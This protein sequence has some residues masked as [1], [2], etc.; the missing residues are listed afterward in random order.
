MGLEVPI[1]DIEDME[2]LYYCIING[3][4]Q[5]KKRYDKKWL[6]YIQS[7]LVHDKIICGI[8]QYTKPIY[9]GGPKIIYPFGPFPEL[10]VVNL[11]EGGEVWPPPHIPGGLIG[12]IISKQ[13]NNAVVELTQ[14]GKMYLGCYMIN[15]Y[16]GQS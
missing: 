14:Y 13:G 11:K 6:A 9:S 16:L 4:E 8:P 5:L 3:F 2:S 12:Y 10:S 15:F 7:N 1:G